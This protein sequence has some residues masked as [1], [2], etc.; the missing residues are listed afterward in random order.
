M[1][2]TPPRLPRRWL[3]A[4]PL[5][6]PTRCARHRPGPPPAGPAMVQ[7]AGPTERA[8]TLVSA[9]SRSS[10]SMR[11]PTAWCS[12]AKVAGSAGSR[13]VASSTRVRCSAAQSQHVQIGRRVTHPS[14]DGAGDRRAGPAVVNP[15]RPGLT[16]VMQQASQQEKIRAGHLRNQRDRLH[17]GLDL[18]PVDR[19]PMDRVALRVTSHTGPLGNPR[20]DDP[21]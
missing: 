12:R 20:L 3:P 17:D 9:R 13:R 7:A 15:G 16:H 14:S 18:M 11:P 4:P 2:P 19:V 8:S 10:W 5:P 1:S 21:G 6:D